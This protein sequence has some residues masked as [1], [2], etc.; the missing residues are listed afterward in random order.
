MTQRTI[1]AALAF[2]VSALWLCG[3]AS[4]QEEEAP[5]SA[6]GTIF[7]ESVPAQADNFGGASYLWRF[8]AAPQEGMARPPLEQLLVVLVGAPEVAGAEAQVVLRGVRAWPR[9]LALA[10]GS[11][12]TFVNEDPLSYTLQV[13]GRAMPPLSLEAAGGRASVTLDKPGRYAFQA[14]GYA[15]LTTYVIVGPLAGSSALRAAGPQEAS[16]DLG[17]LPPGS[18][19]FEIYFRGERLESMR[20]EVRVTP[21]GALEPARF[22]LKRGDFSPQQRP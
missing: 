20:R 16:F 14:P 5:A 18:Y 21:A 11:A 19:Q 13:S 1:I 2:W 17:A 6:R 12:V 22:L 10:P 4:A 7:F 9:A 15:S 3:A 8:P